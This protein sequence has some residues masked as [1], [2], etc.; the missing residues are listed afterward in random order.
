MAPKLRVTAGPSQDQMKPITVNSGRAHRITSNLFDGEVAA[1]IKDFYFRRYDR[2]GVTWSIQVRGRFLVPHSADDILFGNTFDRPFHL[3]WGTSAVL[4]YIDPTL[5]HDLQSQTK[6]WALSPLLSTMPHFAHH[7]IRDSAQSEGPFP[8]ST[9]LQDNTSELHF[10]SNTIDDEDEEIHSEQPTPTVSAA[11]SPA[12]S[13]M[14][15]P[16]TSEATDDTTLNATGHHLQQQMAFETAA[17]RRSFFSSPENRQKVM[18]G[19][20]DV[21]TTDFC[22]GF[23]QFSPTLSLQIPGGFSFDLGKYWD[24]QPVRFVCCERRKANSPDPWGKLFWCV[25]IEMVDED[26][27]MD[28]GEDGE[29]VETPSTNSDID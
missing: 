26:D 3:P 21:I 12:P 25:S 15:E 17:E 16:A 9:S 11:T 5:E 24:G 7:R 14:V 29:V 6:P 19:P 20:L 27:E 10:A 22:Y 23:L 1:Y 8:P 4:N 18:F 2:Q 13:T 28:E